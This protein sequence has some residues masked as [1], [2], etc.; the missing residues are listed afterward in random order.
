MKKFKVLGMMS[1][2]SLDGLD[3][4]C[5]HFCKDAEGWDFEIFQTNTISYSDDLYQNL[6]NA[7]HLSKQQHQQLHLDYGLWLG[8]Q[9]KAFIEN[10]KLQIDFI[11]SHGHTSHHRPEEG[12]T[13][14]LGEGQQLADASGHQVICD[15]R[16]LDVAL[17]GQGAPLVPVGDALLFSEYRFCLNLG[18]IS[19]ISFDKNGTSVI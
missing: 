12:I 4:A 5:C 16:S 10:H 9:A 18:G 15:F 19:N 8:Q 2:T 11:A 14:Q 1:G 6:K 17:G 7:I 13:F 3:M